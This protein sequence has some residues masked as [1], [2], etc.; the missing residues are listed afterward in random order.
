[1]NSDSSIEQDIKK[2]PFK[3]WFIDSIPLLQLQSNK[4]HLNVWYALA[5]LGTL[6]NGGLLSVFED[7]WGRMPITEIPN[8]M[9]EVGCMDAALLFEE[10]LALFPNDSV[11]DV[12]LRRKLIGSKSRKSSRLNKE[13]EE[14]GYMLS[15]ATDNLSSSVCT[16]IISN[17]TDFPEHKKWLTYYLSSEP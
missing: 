1:M 11:N 17:I 2:Y 5:V 9:R 10:A 15:K 14:I 3:L 16:Y 7:G 13:I 8:V 12:D 4:K 6:S